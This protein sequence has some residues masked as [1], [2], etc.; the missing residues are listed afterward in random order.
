MIIIQLRSP[1]HGIDL[2]FC[3]CQTL[4]PFFTR[5]CITQVT[6]G[7][8]LT[9]YERVAFIWCIESKNEI[10]TVHTQK[11]KERAAHALYLRPRPHYAG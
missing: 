7:T 2:E 10:K 6:T 11:S 8:K 9:I 5:Y 3:Y 4:L 1:Y